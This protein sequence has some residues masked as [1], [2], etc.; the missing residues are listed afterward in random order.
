[1]FLAIAIVLAVAW[2]LG[3][4]VFKVSAAA[5]H[6]LIVLAVIGLVLHFVRG[7][8]AAPAGGSAGSPSP[9]AVL[10]DTRARI[11]PKNSSDRSASAAVSPRRPPFCCFGGHEATG[12]PVVLLSR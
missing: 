4:I 5:I 6:L 9:P 2:L 1:M 3:L 12:R 10:G 8:R 11:G 7:G